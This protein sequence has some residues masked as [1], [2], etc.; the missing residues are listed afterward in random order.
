M[1][2]AEL[3]GGVVGVQDADHR[4]RCSLTV[5]LGVPLHYTGRPHCLPVSLTSLSYPFRDLPVG[6]SESEGHI[7]DSQ[8]TFAA[9]P[10]G[11]FWL[12]VMTLQCN[13][14]EIE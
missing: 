14:K 12:L 3:K 11:G 7:I 10:E 5:C 2:S 6:V 4:L 13:V 1:R 8:S 9:V